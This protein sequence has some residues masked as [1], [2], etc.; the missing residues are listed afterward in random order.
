MGI[1]RKLKLTSLSTFHDLSTFVS[2]VD[3]Y[4][5]FWRRSYVFDMNSDDP[6]VKVNERLRCTNTIP[7]ERSSIEAQGHLCKRDGNLLAFKYRQTALGETDILSS[8]S[9]CTWNLTVPHSSW[10]RWLRKM[11]T[12][13]APWFIRVGRMQWSTFSCHLEKLPS[14]YKYMFWTLS[15]Q[16]KK[17]ELLSQITLM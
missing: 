3:I 6:S 13:S 5:Q 4:H 2:A 1:V 9:E 11:T 17:C 7:I 14:I 12:G 16:A 10:T 15:R 8:S